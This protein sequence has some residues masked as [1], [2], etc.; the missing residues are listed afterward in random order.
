MRIHTPL[1]LLT[2]LVIGALVATGLWIARI[3]TDI[4]RYLPSDAPAIADAG[5]IFQHHPMQGQMAIDLAVAAPNPELLTRTARYV[6]NRLQ[7]SGLFRQ[8]GMAAMQALM[9]E[10]L[11]HVTEQL[12]ILFTAEELQTRVG[13]LLSPDQ[14]QSRLIALRHQ[15]LG[16][17][18]I[19][20]ASRISRD[21]LALG[22]IVLARLAHLAPTRDV[23][24]LDGRPLSSDGRHLL[25]VAT[26]T[27]PGADTAFALRLETFLA[28]LAD[29]VAL[30]TADTEPVALTPMGAYRAALDNERIAR[31]DVQKAIGLATLGI[32]LLLLIAFPRPLLGLFAF[33]PAAAGTAAAFFILA[34]VHDTISIMAIGFGG[35]V[36]SITVDHGIAYLL[37]LDQTQTTYGRRASREIWAIGLVA[38]LTSIGA[39]AALNLTGF[40]VLAQLG[41]FAALGIGLA[42]LFVHY[43]LPKIFPEMPP[44]RQRRLPLWQLVN[45]IPTAGKGT[46]LAALA[47]ALGMLFFAKPVFDTG[48]GRMNT[49]GPETA[50]AEALMDRVWGGGVFERIYVM[51][52]APD[53][54]ALQAIGDRLLTLFQEDLTQQRLAEGF[55]PGMLFPGE[56]RRAANFRA[57]R[58]FWTPERR[59]TVRAALAEQGGALGFAPGAFTPFLTTLER[60][61]PPPSAAV[62]AA[63]HDLMGIVAGA[64]GTWMQFATLTAGPRHDPERFHDRYG[65]LA[66]LFDPVFFSRTLGELLFTT[67]IKM[68]AVVGLSVALLIFFFFFD[69]K[70]TAITL[71]PL[72]FALVCTLGTL[73]LIGHPLDIPGLMLAI[74]VLGM[75]TDY[76]LLLV[77]AYQRYGGFADPGFERIRMA[78]LMAACSTLLGFGVLCLAEH[79]LL[80]SAG[81]TSLLGIG[82]ALIGAFVLLPPML[83]HHLQHRSTDAPGTATTIA[84]RILRRYR[85][86]EP[87]PRLFARFKLRHDMLF[88]E[89]ASHLEDARPPRTVLDIGCGYG[90]PG[91]WM[92]E[93]F[94]SAHIHAID[95]DPE[96]ARV[97]ARVFGERG[98]V[99]SADAPHWPPPAEPAEMVL[100]LDVI[101]FLDAPTLHRTLA[102]LHRHMAPQGLLLIRT[103]VPPDGTRASFHWVLDA[104]RMKMAGIVAHHRPAAMA[105]RMVQAA[106]FTI[107]QIAPSGDNPELAW[108]IALRP[109][110]TPTAAGAKQP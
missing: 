55:L 101:H 71:A 73:N 84:Q 39:F 76:A 53:P 52:T 61:A 108:V 58:E 27:Q 38:A 59:A 48:L 4:T 12:P 56:R 28:T 35:A 72:L 107:Q 9:P 41:Q 54:A 91:C 26:P 79:Q 77:R 94:A 66:K 105:A 102:R 24:L 57:W 5:A 68:L 43:A 33:L 83:A 34:L 11:T 98:T 42:F 74:V 80:Y 46:A 15:L 87:Y 10:L 90:V 51:T 13:P 65:D 36:I 95:P 69:L 19:G 89:L 78:V 22:E 7:E 64:D 32:A 86:L 17:D 44:A 31:R 47:F 92:L 8:V 21:P 88:C 85:P 82:Y 6:E 96:R 103:V 2:L 106:G 20:Q 60:T 70:L 37:F 18:A 23:D 100:L 25:V 109:A 81:I 49:V 50:A 63:F 62:P 45:R 1:F 99:T 29:E 110:E 93:R 14:I 67:F 97:A 16:L 104:L 75:G 3:D 30:R 40:P